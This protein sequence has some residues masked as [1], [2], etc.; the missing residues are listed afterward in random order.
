MDSLLLTTM[1]PVKAVDE[2]REKEGITAFINHVNH[3]CRYWI[4]EA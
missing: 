4:K 2:F 3:D 1:A